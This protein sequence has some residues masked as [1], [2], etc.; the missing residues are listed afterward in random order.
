[1]L[2]QEERKWAVNSH[3]LARGARGR[4][5]GYLL[6]HTAEGWARCDAVCEHDLI[7]LTGQA[8]VELHPHQCHL[9]PSGSQNWLVAAPDTFSPDEG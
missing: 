8:Q 1:M 4:Y 7:S 5:L 9:W 2:R 6:F 3:N